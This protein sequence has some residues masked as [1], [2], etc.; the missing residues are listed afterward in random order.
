[1]IWRDDDIG[2]KTSLEE[3]RAV[4]DLFQASG[5][6]QHT[7]AVVAAGLERRP[8]LVNFIRERRMLVQLHCWEHH[9]LSLDTKARAM[10]PRAV[11][12]LE[13]LF[14][15]RPT[16]LYPPWNQTNEALHEAAAALG[17]R[18]SATKVSLAQFLRAGGDVRED[19]INFHYWHAPDVEQL[20]PAIRLHLEKVALMK[21]TDY[22]PRAAPFD[23]Y[24]RG[25]DLVGVEVGV[26]AGAHA[27]AL[28]RH[29]PIAHLHLVDRWLKEYPL[30]FCEGRLSALGFRSR[31][32]R[33]AKGSVQASD[34]FRPESL[35][36]VYID[37]EH[38]GAVVATD[39]R[40]W[41]PRVKRGGVLG[42]RNYSQTATPLKDAV[43]AFIA[44]QPGAMDVH[45]EAGEIVLVKR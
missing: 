33:I 40:V 19:T 38:D 34:L 28:L 37:Q 23:T 44:A 15:R 5:L 27:E 8:D 29:A 7:I 1:M 41:W 42:Y 30:G 17:L 10:L 25:R 24:L 20:A 45:L 4:D 22:C 39:L 31:F 14:Q 18:V 13:Q 2:A 43:D 6:V 32:T 9:D 36:F 35:D 11:D 12:L 26:D 3:L 21:I 16:V